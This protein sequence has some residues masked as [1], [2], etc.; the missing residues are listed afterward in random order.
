MRRMAVLLLA[1]AGFAAGADDPSGF[2]LLT[3]SELRNIDQ[4]LAQ[5]LGAQKSGT[6]QI[7]DYGTHLMLLAH[8]EATGQAEIHE[9]MTDI[10]VIQSGEASLTV[11]GKL[12]D[13]KSTAPGEIRGTSIEGGVTRKL[14]AGD[15]VN[16]PAGTPHHTQVG[17]GQKVTYLV[18]KVRAK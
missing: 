13:G 6:Q 11:G 14:G 17:P 15:V 1:L 2:I 12:V 4:Q 5:K 7:R 10:F 8:V 16:I 9:N 3:S 18:I